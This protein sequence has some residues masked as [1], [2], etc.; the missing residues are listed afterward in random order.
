MK[1][2]AVVPFN[3]N[4]MEVRKTRVPVKR[5]GFLFVYCEKPFA[6]DATLYLSKRKDTLCS[7]LT[8]LHC[9]RQQIRQ[10]PLLPVN[11]DKRNDHVIGMREL[12]GVNE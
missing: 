1:L 11:K 4:E 6:D 9:T 5:Y 3:I 10:F 12:G 8:C 2:Y 7:T